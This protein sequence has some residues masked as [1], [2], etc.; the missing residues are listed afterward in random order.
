MSFLK[1]N[2]N[3]SEAEY[4]ALLKSIRVNPPF[5]KSVTVYKALVKSIFLKPLLHKS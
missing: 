4:K 2:T 1:L 5:T 3:K